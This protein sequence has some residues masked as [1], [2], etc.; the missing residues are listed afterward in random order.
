VEVLKNLVNEFSSFARLP[1]SRPTPNNLNEIVRE[2]VFLYKEG[3]K[4]IEFQT[5]VGEE[6]PV[7]ELD[8]DQIKR[9]IMNLLDNAVAA[10]GAGGR[11]EIA[12]HHDAD[13]GIVALEV[14]DNGHGILP[15]VR[16]RLFEPYFSTKK[17]GTG[18]GL[19]IV[20]TIVADHRGYIR[21]RNNEPTGTRFIVE[22]PVK[23]CDASI[24]LS[25]PQA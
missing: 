21:V 20:S 10:V 8:Q 12:T 2:V 16:S 17:D 1:A 22:F 7:L 6:I 5:Q 9:V 18:L 19:A 13:L 11:I 4:E 3:H 25:I 23:Q 15:E 14:A 24:S